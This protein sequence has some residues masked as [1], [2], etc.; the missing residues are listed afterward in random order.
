MGSLSL[1][2]TLKDN[3]YK[4]PLVSRDEYFLDRLA[5]KYKFIRC[6]WNPRVLVSDKLSK[7]NITVEFATYKVNVFIND[8]IVRV[9]SPNW[10]DVVTYGLH[11]KVEGAIEYIKNL[12]RV[13]KLERLC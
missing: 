3:G 9:F 12:E 4:H 8:E 11:A 5:I 6:L 7:G 10:S 2:L 1:W 13:Q